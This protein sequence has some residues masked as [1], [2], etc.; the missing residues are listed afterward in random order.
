MPITDQIAW[1]YRHLH[2]AAVVLFRFP[3]SVGS[4]QPIALYE[5]GMHA[6]RGVPIAV[7]VD[8]SYARRR[9]VEIQLG[10]AQ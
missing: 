5:L 7:G 1:E 3:R 9:D 6:G 2:R 10:L 8:R 4:V